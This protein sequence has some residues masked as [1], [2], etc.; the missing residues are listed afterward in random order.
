[1][2]RFLASKKKKQDYIKQLENMMKAENEKSTGLQAN[3]FEAL[4]NSL[5]LI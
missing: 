5:T 2:A 3:Y 4:R 1:M